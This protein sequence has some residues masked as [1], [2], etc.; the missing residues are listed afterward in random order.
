MDLVYLT[1]TP[2]PSLG[3][4]EGEADLDGLRAAVGIYADDPARDERRE[5][6]HAHRG[7]PS[8]HPPKREREKQEERV[9]DGDVQCRKSTKSA[10]RSAFPSRGA[11][12]R[13]ARACA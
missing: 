2:R 7:T 10:L 9:A 1:D 8:P 6:A 12:C 11:A 3:S 4:I 13:R 5:R